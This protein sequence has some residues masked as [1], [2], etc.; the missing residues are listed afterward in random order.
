MKAIIHDIIESLRGGVPNEELQELA[1][2]IVEELTGL[3]RSEIITMSVL[4]GSVELDRSRVQQVIQRIK[5]N[6]PVQYIFGHTN[7]RGLDLLVDSGTLIPRPETSELV[8]WV[9]ETLGEAENVRFMDIG[10]GSGCIA[11]AIK[12]KYPRATV[13]ALD[14]SSQ[15]LQVAQRNADKYGFDII[16]QQ[17]DVLNSELEQVDVIISNPPY[18]CVQERS[19]MDARVLDYEPETALFVPDDDP[20][21]FYRRIAEQR[22]SKMLF[23]EINEAYGQ[24]VCEMLHKLGYIDVTV[25]KDFYG[26]TRMVFGRIA[27]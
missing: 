20:L 23:F 2:W 1:Y 8:D 3:S 19:S 11:I 12:Q 13:I 10:T 26:K 22:A 18:I 27:E 5:K 6:E 21:L 7:W 15:A 16:W 14:V 4:G 25:K 17:K 9:L 24:E